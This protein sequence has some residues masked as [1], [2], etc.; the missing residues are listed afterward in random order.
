[1]RKDILLKDLHF[2]HEAEPPINARKVGREEDIDTLAAS[3]DSHGMGQALNVREIKKRVYVVDGNRRLAAL[4]LLEKKGNIT[5]DTLVKCE[6]DEKDGVS[7]DELSLALNI[8]R[9]AMHEAD[10]YEAFRRLHEAGQTD[11]QIA[12]RFG[13]PRKVVA[14]TLALGRL[15]PMILDAWRENKLGNDPIDVVKAFTIA[16]SIKEQEAVFKR[17]K[18]NNSLQ[19]YYIRQAFG[20]G[21]QQQAA[22][23]LKFV[24]AAAYKAAGGVII[25]DLFQEKQM[26][27]DP[28]LV[29]KLA[30]DK[31]VA[32]RDELRAEGWAWVEID[33]DMPNTDWRY[34]WQRNATKKKPTTEEKAKSGCVV[35]LEGD[36]MEVLAGIVKPAK[37]K[38]APKAEQ[39]KAGASPEKAAAGPA[40]ISNAMV[41]SLRQMAFR[42]TQ[43]ALKS[44]TYSTDLARVLAGVVSVQ[45]N[46]GQTWHT[47]SPVG[48]KLAAIRDSV[49]P[50]VMEA[51]LKKHFDTER[52]FKNVPKDFV[53]KAIKE[54]VSPEQ[55]KK[56]SGGTKVAAWK[57]ALENV[58]KTGWLP[59]ELRTAHYAGPGA[60]VAKAEKPAS[61][62]K[63]AA[64][65]TAKKAPLKKAA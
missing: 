35:W 32:K 30:R 47:P 23:L 6:F 15:S 40:T 27:S 56:L 44:K 17:L 55:A 29:A 61:K 46:A 33:D 45:I 51:A 22:T 26:I 50:A 14:K 58:V 5:G 25:D 24:G 20:A 52:Y 62:P 4:R 31:L 41:E 9:V 39:Q 43:D 60:K 2:G 19:G 10:E 64:K 37:G 1:M 3:I 59:P 8:E 12:S 48:N 53:L 34:V 16:P 21:N 38:A 11:Q 18:A 42:A 7:A 49:T 63:P 13:L 57:F 54:A 28:A 36:K 65:K